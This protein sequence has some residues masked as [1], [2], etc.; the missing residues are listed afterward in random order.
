VIH[1]TPGIFPDQVRDY[2]LLM[3]RWHDL[4]KGVPG[5][6]LHV[7]AEA[8]GYPLMSVESAHWNP[9]APAVYFSAGI[10]GDEPAPVEAVIRWATKS[11]GNKELRWWNWQIFPCLNPW[12]LERNIRFDSEG[13][14]LNRYY[15]SKRVPQIAAQLKRLKERDF[16]AAV[17]L[18][19]D[20]DARGF[21]LYEIA[22]SR[23]YWGESLCREVTPAMTPDPRRKIDGHSARHGL[24]RRRI[25][26]TLMKGHPEAFRLHF[27]HA[28]RT[29][30]LETPSE[31]GLDHRILLQKKFLGA[32]V[33]RVKLSVASRSENR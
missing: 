12:G 9:S 1:A 17:A 4:V 18:H 22:A 15:H 10:H 27:H 19:E 28:R 13:R 5:I 29:F 2:R 8:G 33:K 31:A 26:P 20:Y 25:T 32:I 6:D 14:D 11:L 30:T 7:F 3:Q 21:Y 24:I 16:D 23:P